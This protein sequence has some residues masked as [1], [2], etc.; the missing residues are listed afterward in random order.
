MHRVRPL[1]S[2]LHCIAAPGSHLDS[3]VIEDGAMVGMGARVLAGAV[4]GKDSYIDAGAVVGPGEVVPGGS[5]WTGN[6]AKE[7]RK[8][9]VDEMSFLRNQAAVYAELAVEHM[10]EE[11]KGADDVLEDELVVEFKRRAGMPLSR[12]LE[13]ETDEYKAALEYKGMMQMPK[14]TGL[15]REVEYDD[16]GMRAQLQAEAIAADQDEEQFFDHAMRFQKVAALFETLAR[17]PG[18]R[19]GEREAY[20]GELDARDEV[21]AAYAQDVLRRCLEAEGDEA[22]QVAMERELA[23]L[24]PR[25]ATKHSFSASEERVALAAHAKDAGMLAEGEGAAGASQIPASSSSSAAAEEARQ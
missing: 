19:A 3:C 4:V 12:P 24:D 17:I 11:S 7:L 1:S 10:K 25:K 2:P 16:D 14:D 9:T 6:P 23:M 20:I 15:F 22:K 5:L 18:D 21:A 13:D 8:L